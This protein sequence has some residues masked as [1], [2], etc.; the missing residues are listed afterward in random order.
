MKKYIINLDRS[1]ERMAWMDSAFRGMGLAYVRVSAVDGQL[2]SKKKRADLCAPRADGLPWTDAEV[3]VLLSH[4]KCWKMIASGDED[5]GVI[6]EDDIHFS[7]DA[8][9]FLRDASWIP[10]GA[11]L[12]KLETTAQV[13][14]I[15]KSAV[16]V[17][18]HRLAR[19]CAAHWGAGAY[20]VSREL[21]RRLLVQVPPLR[22]QVDVILFNP[23]YPRC[24][25]TTYQLF[26]SICIQDSVLRNDEA[27]GDLASTLDAERRRLRQRKW[28]PRGLR[29]VLRELSR[30]FYQL[31]RILVTWRVNVFSERLVTRI[32]FAP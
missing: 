1:T 3:G 5:Y 32:P 12:I 8:S 2:L 28:K 4:R 24:D 6:F 21:A 10:R 23:A 16:T 17:H 30:P 25:F 14:T 20:I 22:D 11:E 18:S 7:G 9:N 29:K 27:G 26:P 13:T 19:L 31:A 15:E